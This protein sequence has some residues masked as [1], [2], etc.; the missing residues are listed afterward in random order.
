MMKSI[1]RLGVVLAMFAAAA[2]AALAVVYAVTA[3]TIEAQAQIALEASLKEIFPD[4]QE[5]EDITA[6][7][8]S[9][10]PAVSFKSAYLVKG[11][12]APVG[13]AVKAGASSYG[14]EAILLVGT[15][16]DRRIAG[17][18][19]LEHKDTP[20]LGANA[21]N[22][23]YY[24]KKADKLTFPGQ[25]AGKPLTDAFTVKQDVIAITAST[26]TSK[27]LTG[28]VKASGAA[29]AAYLEAAATAGGK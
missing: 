25:F 23:G 26:I 5:F 16:L 22:P 9:E 4:A 12:G 3:D 6:T 1:V 24:V 27:A 19:V 29:S 13:V 28:I 17:V 15:A 11:G 18:R 8:K 2:C 20:G 21:A 10:D 7:V 14:G